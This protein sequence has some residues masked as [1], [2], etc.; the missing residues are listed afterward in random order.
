MDEIKTYYCKQYTY[1]YPDCYEG[2]YYK[3]I[4][5]EDCDLWLF[6]EWWLS[7]DC[8]VEE[9]AFNF[10]DHGSYVDSDTRQYFELVD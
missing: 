4:L 10:S 5:D 9:S 7:E 2:K 1:E 6:D 3:G 8:D